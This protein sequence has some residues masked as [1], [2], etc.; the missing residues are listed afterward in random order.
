MDGASRSR[1]LDVRTATRASTA[2]LVAPCDD[3]RKTDN[4]GLANRYESA[5]REPRGCRSRPLPARAA[6]RPPIR[7]GPGMPFGGVPTGDR[8]PFPE[9]PRPRTALGLFRYLPPRRND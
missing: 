9:T 4:D 5:S 8:L 1:L 2:P 3:G 7:L 6:G